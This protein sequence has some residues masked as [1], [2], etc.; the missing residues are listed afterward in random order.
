VL[1]LSRLG[2]LAARAVIVAGIALAVVVGPQQGAAMAA[3]K[4]A[5]GEGGGEVPPDVIELVRQVRQASIVE[6]WAGQRAQE[7]SSN[8]S[9]RWVGMSLLTDHIF[10]DKQMDQIAEQ[11]KIELPKEPTLQQQ[12]GI[13]KM[14]RET[15]PEFDRAFSGSLFFGHDTVMKLIKTS[16]AQVNRDGINPLA[17]QLVDVA[18]R[19]VTKHMA[20]LAATGLVTSASTPTADQQDDLAREVSRTQTFNNALPLAIGVGSLL[21]LIVAIQTALFR[22]R[23]G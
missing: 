12:S 3:T 5:Q 4:S 16:Q 23:K 19:F 17:K 6:I 1:G 15:G 9:V 8:P 7:Q 10:L 13:R 18:D 14:A 2:T 21:V 20:W 11:L 22:K